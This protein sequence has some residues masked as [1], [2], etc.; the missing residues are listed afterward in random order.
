[1]ALD[2]CLTYRIDP[3]L[4]AKATHVPSVLYVFPAIRIGVTNQQVKPI[5]EPSDDRRK[6]K[7]EQKRRYLFIPHVTFLFRIPLRNQ[8]TRE[9]P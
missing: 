6:P 3:L 5:Q 4:R 7:L 8:N 2:R 1:M 9:A